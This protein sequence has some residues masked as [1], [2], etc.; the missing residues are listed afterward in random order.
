MQ[1]PDRRMPND[2]EL[3]QGRKLAGQSGGATGRGGTPHPRTT[4]R[5]PFVI[6]HRSQRLFSLAQEGSVEVTSVTWVATARQRSDTQ[7]ARPTNP[8]LLREGATAWLENGDEVRI[9]VISDIHADL[10]AL[11]RVQCS[12]FGKLASAGIDL[13]DAGGSPNA[14]VAGGAA[15]LD[16]VSDAQSAVTMETRD[17]EN[18]DRL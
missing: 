2:V 9:A 8:I 11:E 14:A 6:K 17:S 7:A 3:R 16:A 10:E 4:G 12:R 5:L 18:P 13:H 15:S 1:K